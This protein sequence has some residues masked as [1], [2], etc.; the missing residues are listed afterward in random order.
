MSPGP[1]FDKMSKDEIKAYFD[2]QE[3]RSAK[4]FKDAPKPEV[5]RV[6][7]E[8]YPHFE[9]VGWAFKMSEGLPVRVRWPGPGEPVVGTVVGLRD[10]DDQRG[11][12]FVV[13]L[14]RAGVWACRR[15][16]GEPWA[17]GLDVPWVKTPELDV[18]AQGWGLASRPDEGAR[19]A[20]PHRPQPLWVRTARLE[21]DE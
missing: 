10:V 4:S 7:Q 1:N 21:E 8:D 3:R 20:G 16:D 19:V 5:S 14:G 9:A 13:D 17:S 15:A 6:K 2:E 12:A 18:A 11:L